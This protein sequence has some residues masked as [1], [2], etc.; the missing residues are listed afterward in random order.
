MTKTGSWFASFEITLEGKKVR[1]DDLSEATQEWIAEKIKEGCFFGEIVEDSENEAQEMN[2]CPVCGGEIDP[3][4]GQENGYG[5]LHLY[6][7]CDSC[8]NTGKAIIDMH[9]DNRFI[10][11]EVD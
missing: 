9:D 1:W 3:K 5:E 6:W 7:T 2:I 8:G 10:G 4:D 11:H